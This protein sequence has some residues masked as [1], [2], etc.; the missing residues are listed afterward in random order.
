[1]FIF[2][3][4]PPGA[5]KST[6]GKM[7]ADRLK[8]MFTDLD[9]LVESNAGMPIPQIMQERGEQAFRDLETIALRDVIRGRTGVVALGGGALLREENRRLAEDSG[10]VVCMQTSLQLLLA[11]LQSESDT[12]PL[13]AGDLGARLAALLEKREGHYK[14][15]PLIVDA[16]LPPEEVA[17]KTQIAAGWF[18]LSSMAEYDALVLPGGLDRLGSLLAGRGLIRPLV[19]TDE[20]VSKYYSGPALDSLRGAGYDPVLVSVPPGESYKTL[21]TVRSLWKGFLDA[22]LDRGGT[23]VALGGGVIGDLAGF[24]AATY[25]RGVHWTAVPTTLLS[26]VDASL[27]GKTGFD[28]PEGK[29]LIGAFHPPRLVLADPQ[30]LST[31]PEREL[32]AGLAEVVKHGVI[33]D[34]KLFDMCAGG[35]EPV[36]AHLDEIVRR[37]MAV[38]IRI[39]EQDP[40][41][42]GARAALNV[43]HTLGHA[44]ELASGFRLRHGEAVAV[45]MVAEARLAERLTV[46]DPG[47]AD[48]IA[49]ALSGLGLPVSI[50]ADVPR[51][52]VLRA[53]RVDKKKSG[54]AIRFALP[55]AIGKVQVGVEV[56]DLETVFEEA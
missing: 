16:S 46:A 2:L 9:H 5:G 10:R 52:E 29:N 39:I 8:T 35:F 23:V 37:A 13:L 7:L 15:F 20:T 43:G 6:V 38:K 11:R 55:A 48:A 18:H 50:P 1:M 54:H 45:G 53:M 26:M 4:G 49:A 3:Y 24:A 33:G 40:F 22:G 17:R 19:V 47:V 36:M 14:S 28:L 44:V 27:G 34:P 30:T 42:R 32:R 31:L 25:M 51:Q 21:E 41:E 12:R 56:T